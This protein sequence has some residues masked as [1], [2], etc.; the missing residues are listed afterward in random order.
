MTRRAVGG[1]CER[2]ARVARAAAGI[3]F[4]HPPVHRG[5]LYQVRRIISGRVS[6]ERLCAEHVRSMRASG[7]YGLEA[8]RHE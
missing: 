6:D 2:C 4:E 3:G 8:V 5:E 7:L 1:E